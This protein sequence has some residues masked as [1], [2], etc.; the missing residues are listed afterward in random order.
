MQAQ[1]APLPLH[2]LQSCPEGNDPLAQQDLLQLSLA[3]EISDLPLG[4]Q[5]ASGQLG[6]LL[7]ADLTGCLLPL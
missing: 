7:C 4:V 1:Q 6:L 2:A 5:T 3:P